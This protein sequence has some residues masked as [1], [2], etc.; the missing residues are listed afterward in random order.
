MIYEYFNPHLFNIKQ[1]QRNIEKALPNIVVKL[2]DSMFNLGLNKELELIDLGCWVHNKDHSIS[3]ILKALTET[4]DADQL[5]TEI[6]VVQ[7]LW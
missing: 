4:L 6:E 7:Y 5:L 1:L 3:N 2:N